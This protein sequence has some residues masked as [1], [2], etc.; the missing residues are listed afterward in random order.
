MLT[1]SP[2]SY[3][4]VLTSRENMAEW[5]VTSRDHEMKSPDNKMT[6]RDN[7]ITTRDNKITT[8]N[9][10]LK[11][12]DNKLK[13]LEKKIKS[14]DNSPSLL[15]PTFPVSV[16]QDKSLVLLSCDQPHNTEKLHFLLA[17]MHN[18]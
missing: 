12:R 4:H 7:K 13:S 15:D 17:V 11:S 1:E 6:T 18:R 10:K 14:R 8:R 9:N 5:R 2:V 16:R 3:S